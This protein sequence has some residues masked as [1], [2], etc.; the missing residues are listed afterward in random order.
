MK[1]VVF[2]NIVDPRN[3]GDMHCNPGRLT[4]IQQNLPAGWR[5]E[6]CDFRNIPL[7][8]NAIVF[9][10]GGMLHPGVD[11][12]LARMTKYAPCACWGVGVNYHFDHAKPWRWRETLT[13]MRGP[14]YIRDPGYNW[15]QAPCPSCLDPRIEVSLL[16][17]NEDERL[18]EGLPPSLGRT[19]LV[20]S[21]HQRRLPNP[22]NWPFALNDGS[23]R[24]ED[25]LVMIRRSACVI[26]NTFHG[27]YWSL[28]LGI[29]VFLLRS[30]I[31]STRHHTLINYGAVLVDS[32]EYISNLG[33]PAAQTP[34]LKS[35]KDRSFEVFGQIC[36][37]LSHL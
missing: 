12:E 15:P 30:E 1:T 35:H 5:T 20:I 3:L 25:L 7:K 33:R 32:W 13:A 17:R 6:V 23:T 26:T 24:F 8:A 19:P 10:G 2:A 9:G 14:S 27:G 29:P 31:F 37:W 28:L 22:S 11:A 34:L 4:W 18:R 16:L 36:N 21:H